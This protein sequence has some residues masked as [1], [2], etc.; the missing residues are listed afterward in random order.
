MANQSSNRSSTTLRVSSAEEFTYL[1]SLGFGFTGTH[2]EILNVNLP[3][4]WRQTETG[5]IFDSQDTFRAYVRE[6]A[7]NPIPILFRIIPDFDAL[8]PTDPA[9]IAHD[10]TNRDGGFANAMAMRRG[11]PEW[12]EYD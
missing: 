11:T 9:D 4:G 5:S 8:E 12:S 7:G 2:N 6:E 3:E 1:T 10:K